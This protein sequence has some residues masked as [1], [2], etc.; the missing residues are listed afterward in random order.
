MP[1]NAVYYHVAYIAAGIIYVGYAGML[2]WR[3]LRVR[4]KAL[5]T[6]V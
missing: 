2:Y 5:P 1:D 6:V 3:R 4:R